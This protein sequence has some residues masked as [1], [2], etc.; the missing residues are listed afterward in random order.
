MNI[1]NILKGFK[2]LNFKTI[3]F[4]FK[5]L[6]YKQAIFLPIFVS[7]NVKLKNSK[8]NIVLDF[9]PKMRS[10]RLGY[11]AVGIFDHKR[12]KS[13][14]DVKGKIIFKGKA[15][16]GQGFK[17]SVGEKGKIEFGDNFAISA[18]TSLVASNRRIEFGS[19]C[20]LSW[21]VLFLD[22]DF[23]KIYDIDNNIINENKD[24]KIGN[25]VWIGCRSTILKGSIVSDGIVIASNSLVAGILN[26]NNAIYGGVPIKLIKSNVKWER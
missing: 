4:N 21:E 11:E 1:S 18:E 26:S 15:F 25:N 20:L 2:E 22:T 13:I 23:H 3:Y 9:K 6:T 5:Y 24:I 16:I 7:K 12:S 8:G 19:N 17:I 14:W 10:I